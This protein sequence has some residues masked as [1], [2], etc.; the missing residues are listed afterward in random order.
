[1]TNSEAGAIVLG[2]ACGIAFI[3]VIAVMLD[4]FGSYSPTTPSHFLRIASKLYE[5][6]E[7]LSLYPNSNS[8]VYLRDI[9]EYSFQNAEGRYAG[10]RISIDR[11]S[12]HPTFMQINCFMIDDVFDSVEMHGS[13][14]EGITAFL[15]DKHC[16]EIFTEPQT[17]PLSEDSLIAKTKG[18]EETKFFLSQY[19][20]AEVQV[21]RYPEDHAEVVYRVE[22]PVNAPEELRHWPKTHSLSLWI[23]MTTSTGEIKYIYAECGTVHT[24]RMTDDI[25]ES[26]A[27]TDCLNPNWD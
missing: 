5:T 7:F 19:P 14:L 8:T 25:I 18:I 1:M 17:M 13:R 20:D 23:E 4:S 16:P 15:Q 6:Q 26:I 27:T 24:T 2:L 21:T 12:G 22:R 9:V 11:D 10:L 3:V